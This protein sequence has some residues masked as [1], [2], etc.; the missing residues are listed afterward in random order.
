MQDALKIES[1]IFSYAIWVY[2]YALNNN[3]CRWI[4]KEDVILTSSFYAY[5]YAKNIIKARW[6]EAE[7]IIS[8]DARSSYGY[9]IFIADNINRGKL[10]EK[11][12]NMMI[13]HAIED[14]NNHYVKSYFEHLNDYIKF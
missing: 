11:M 2:Y 14:P 13:L 7:D 6:P 12:H 4:E 10:P 1:R 5:S 9:A 8:K 3:K